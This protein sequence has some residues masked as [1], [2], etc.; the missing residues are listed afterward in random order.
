MA[1][2][3]AYERR[4]DDDLRRRASTH[5]VPAGG[6]RFS[7]LTTVYQ[8]TDPSLFA[9]TADCLR[10]QTYP[11]DEWIVLAHGPVQPALDRL[12][13]EYARA[14]RFRL[15]R[16]PEN[17]GIMGG[18]RVCLDAARG[19]Y[20]VPMDADDLLTRDALQ[21]LAAEIV[22]RGAPQLLYS[23]EDILI[24]GVPRAP[25]R[26]PDWDPVLNL[27]SSYVWHLCAIRR[28]DALRLELYTDPGASWCHDWDTMFRVSDTGS[29]PVHIAEV[30]YHWRQ[31][32]ASSTN[33]PDPESGSRR[34]QRHLLERQIAR[35]TAPERY[36]VV[37]FPIFRG[38]PEWH[39][40]RLPVDPPAVD[41]LC[42]GDSQLAPG[43]PAS[44]RRV[45]GARAAAP[46]RR[47]YSR[48]LRGRTD[49]TPAAVTAGAL[50]E[51]LAAGTAP[52][53]ALVSSAVETEG[54]E[55]WW[56]AVRLLELHP[57]VAAVG[58]AVL[59]RAGRI[60]CA[61]PVVDSAGRWIVPQAGRPANDPGPFAIALKPHCV[62]GVPTDLFVAERPLLADVLGALP[63]DAPLSGLGARLG[64]AALSRGRRVVFSPLIRATLCGPSLDE[65][66]AGAADAAVCAA[67][68]AGGRAALAGRV[69]SAAGFLVDAPAA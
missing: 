60:V 54:V 2:R 18:M 53:V 29:E 46:P 69:L 68:D 45:V 44:S 37:E 12:L 66:P 40:S 52:R 50:R 47:W 13:D 28:E 35:R 58:G 51:A 43:V 9:E 4:L 1:G 67:L 26:R 48:L 8:R 20:V 63:A 61:A 64:L 21:V 39:V 19:D 11:F 55:W 62:A 3:S 15:M 25:Y 16:L 22:R 65:A 57:D 59:D 49:G 41:L 34:S 31:H 23:D 27:A 6:P 30:L 24:D 17:L 14:P 36:R 7:L 38:A 32:P 10:A 5:P 42:V 56:E 33:R